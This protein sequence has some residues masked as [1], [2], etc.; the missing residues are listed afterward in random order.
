[1]TATIAAPAAQPDGIGHTLAGLRA[2][3]AIGLVLALVCVLAWLARRG[4]LRL[5]GSKTRVPI[6]IEAAASLGD[7]RSLVVVAVE[8]RRILLGVTPAQ[9]TLVT[10]LAAAPPEFAS[11]LDR[12]TAAPPADGGA[13]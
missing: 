6:R 5:P 2:F 7:R 10:E 12:R 3:G 1:M 8:G 9:I 11:A 13:I 4:T